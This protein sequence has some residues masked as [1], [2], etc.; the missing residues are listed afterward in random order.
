MLSTNT[1]SFEDTIERIN[2]IR[3]RIDN[4]KGNNFSA[5]RQLS[6]D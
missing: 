2:E 6:H 1:K 3:L 5:E 4:I